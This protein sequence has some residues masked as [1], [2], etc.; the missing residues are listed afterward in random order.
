MSFLLN[1]YLPCLIYYWVIL[2]FKTKTI[3]RKSNTLKEYFDNIDE[4]AKDAYIVSLVPI[5]NFIILCFAA[6]SDFYCILRKFWHI[7]G[8]IKLHPFRRNEDNK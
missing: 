6:F 1:T 3:W 8:K 2:F 7:C 5:C 4:A